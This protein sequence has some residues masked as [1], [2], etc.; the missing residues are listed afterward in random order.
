MNVASNRINKFNLKPLNLPTFNDHSCCRL[1]VASLCARSVSLSDFLP[2]FGRG[3]HPFFLDKKG[4]KSQ[5]KTKSSARFS[6]PPAHRR[7]K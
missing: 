7:S 2:L 3:G 6:E 5:G 1:E 4:R